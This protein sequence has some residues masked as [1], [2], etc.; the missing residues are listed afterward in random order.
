MSMVGE[1]ELIR[2]AGIV[3]LDHFQVRVIEDPNRDRVK[4]TV[5]TWPREC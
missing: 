1:L 2:M 4:L 3:D 5:G